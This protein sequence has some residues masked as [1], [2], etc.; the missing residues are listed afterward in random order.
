VV[1]LGLTLLRVRNPHIQMAVWQLVLA[2]SLSMPFLVQWA[3][4]TLPGVLPA[5]PAAISDMFPADAVVLAAPAPQMPLPVGVSPAFP[6]RALAVFVYVSIA[7]LLVKL[8]RCL[9]I[10]SWSASGFCGTAARTCFRP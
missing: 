4:F 2:A 8:Y 1:W 6:W 3:A 9:V 7:V 5:A 10:T